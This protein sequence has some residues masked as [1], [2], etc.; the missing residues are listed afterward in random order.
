MLTQFQRPCSSGVSEAMCPVALVLVKIKGTATFSPF[1]KHLL[2]IIFG[3]LLWVN[4][5]KTKAA[6][7]LH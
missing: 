2:L 4:H 3:A 5:T 1:H 7:R 6:I